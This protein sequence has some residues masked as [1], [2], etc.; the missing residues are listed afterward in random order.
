MLLG[1]KDLT[2]HMLWADFI[3]WQEVIKLSRQKNVQEILDLMFHIHANQH[4]N[5]NIWQNMPLPEFD[6]LKFETLSELYQWGMNFHKKNS[7]FINSLSE[8]KLNE[9]VT[10][11]WIK[12]F[13]EDFGKLPGKTS[14]TDTIF[15][16]IMHATYHRGQVNT[17]IRQRGGEPPLTD[18]I[19][20]VWL[21]KPMP[22]LSNIK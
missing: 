10:L 18:F 1:L 11:P 17:K 3:M 2:N 6:K 5:F 4:A 19:Y 21:G 22:D 16:V 12:S 14:L 9:T 7:K 15:Q 8:Q 20:W 13:E